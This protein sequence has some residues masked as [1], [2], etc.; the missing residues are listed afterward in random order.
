MDGGC[1]G[2][3]EGEGGAGE[4]K[5]L[6]TLQG[7]N[8]SRFKLG[9]LA[10]SP[11]AH[12][13][14]PWTYLNVHVFTVIGYGIILAVIEQV[15]KAYTHT[16]T[17]KHCAAVRHTHAHTHAHNANKTHA[18]P[19]SAQLRVRNNTLALCLWHTAAKMKLL[20]FSRLSACVCL[21]ARVLVLATHRVPKW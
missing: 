17:G 12:P 7:Q 20:H 1:V 18:M 2:G 5:A 14:Q 16:H 13:E 15:F 6:R 8:W 10:L 11:T 4:G 21:C 3:S 9:N 19:R